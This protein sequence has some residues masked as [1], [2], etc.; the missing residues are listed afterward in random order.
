MVLFF[1]KILLCRFGWPP[2]FLVLFPYMNTYIG[3]GIFHFMLGPLIFN[4]EHALR[5]ILAVLFI[6][7]GILYIVFHFVDKKAESGEKAELYK[8]AVKK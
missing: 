6:I 5:V 8:D 4:T 7:I 2:V 3:T 1:V